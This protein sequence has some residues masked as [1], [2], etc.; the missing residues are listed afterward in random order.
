L[1]LSACQ[2]SRGRREQLEMP[3]VRVLGDL[4]GLR[5]HLEILEQMAG[6]VSL[7]H[8]V[9]PDFLGLPA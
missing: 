6:R 2:A 8:L 9:I 5:A 3:A 7:A 1:V 4:E